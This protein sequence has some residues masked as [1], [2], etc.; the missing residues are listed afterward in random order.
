[1]PTW[2][3]PLRH[4]ATD[5]ATDARYSALDTTSPVDSQCSRSSVRESLGFFDLADLKPTPLA[6]LNDITYK[7]RYVRARK[8]KWHEGVLGSSGDAQNEAP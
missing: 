8:R 4:A 5:E 3:V 7:L 2:L 1:M 6:V